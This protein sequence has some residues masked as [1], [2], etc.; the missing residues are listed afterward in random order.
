M[1]DEDCI[2]EYDIFLS[3][4]GVDTRNGFTDHLNAALLRVGLRTFRDNNELERGESLN[5]QL[6]KAI[7]SSAASI[8]VLSPNYAS[9]G[10][11][12]DEVEMILERKRNLQHY[13]E[14]YQYST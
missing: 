8:I 9:S 3:F 1:K 12:L 2:H 7:K 11:C 6:E 4:R 5:P 10:W 14:L 13:K